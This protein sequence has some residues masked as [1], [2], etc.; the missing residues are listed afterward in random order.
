MGSIPT[1]PT[2]HA[3]VAQWSGTSLPTR[4]TP[5]QIRS[6][7]PIHADVA[8]WQSLWFPTRT[9]PVQPRSSAP[10]AHDDPAETLK[11]VKRHGSRCVKRPRS[12]V[13]TSL[14]RTGDRGFDSPRGPLSRL[15]SSCGRAPGFYPGGSR[16]EAG[17]GHQQ[18]RADGIDV[19]RSLINSRM[20]QGQD[21]GPQPLLP[22]QVNKV[23]ALLS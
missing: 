22:G 17:W 20:S 4:P 21:L 3:T 5:V 15:Q 6:V 9:S 8:Q 23:K 13:L 11:G 16:F 14:A 7:A 18:S 19:M 10:L 2:I 12:D 1:S